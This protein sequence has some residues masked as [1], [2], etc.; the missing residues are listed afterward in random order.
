MFAET[1]KDHGKYRETTAFHEA[2]YDSLLTAQVAVRLSTKLEAAGT[3]IEDDSEPSSPDEAGGVT[4]NG[5]AA[6][7]TPGDQNLPNRAAS[8]LSSA[9]GG[10]RQLVSAPLKVLSG[11]GGHSMQ[12]DEAKTDVAAKSK[13]GASSKR[14]NQGLEGESTAKSEPQQSGRFAHAT[15]FDQ[16][17]NTVDEES[18]EEEILQFDDLPSSTATASAPVA[19]DTDGISDNRVRVTAADW[20]TPYWRREGGRAMPRFDSDFWGVYGNKLRIF[21]TQEAVC[22]LDQ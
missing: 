3:Y 21:G 1:H 11:D 18:E 20:E 7:F 15:V 2:G 6:R 22:L 17:Q 8:T 10:L 5:G 14:K 16:L 12:A 13:T 9:I 4:L 19:A